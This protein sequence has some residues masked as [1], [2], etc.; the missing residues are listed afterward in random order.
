MH[1]NWTPWC[2]VRPLSEVELP[3][4]VDGHGLD[5]SRGVMLARFSRPGLADSASPVWRPR[6]ACWATQ[7]TVPVAESVFVVRRGVVGEEVYL[8]V[9]LVAVAVEIG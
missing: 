9:R 4:L 5:T 3:T 1:K 6:L 8:V 7:E 2:V